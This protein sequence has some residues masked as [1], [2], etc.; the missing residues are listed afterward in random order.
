MFEQGFDE[1]ES[2]LAS[3]ASLS[4]RLKLPVEF[5]LLESRKMTLRLAVYVRS[6]K[7]KGTR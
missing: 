7:W 1:P 2:K 5:F 4:V 6:L 3:L